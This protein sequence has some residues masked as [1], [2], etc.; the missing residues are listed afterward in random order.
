MVK[1]T[2]G[3]FFLPPGTTMNG[4][5]Y[6]EL[7]KNKLELHINVH[8]CDIFVQD[9]PYVTNQKLSPILKK[10]EDSGLG[11]ARQQSRPEPN[12]KFV[13]GFEN[14]SLSTTT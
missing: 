1:G 7:Q 8:Q 2:T 11:L 4:S 3:L 13:A 10:K 6:F 9:G 5:K 12:Q 14:Q